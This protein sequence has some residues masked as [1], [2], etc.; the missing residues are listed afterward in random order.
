MLTKS[1]ILRFTALI[2]GIVFGGGVSL[3]LVV[4][5]A[6]FSGC[7]PGGSTIGSG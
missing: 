2:L 1:S 5:W 4:L 6:C 3:G 7:L